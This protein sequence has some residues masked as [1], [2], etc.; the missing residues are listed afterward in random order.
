MGY[1]PL[2]LEPIKA[3]ER[4][5]EGSG[6]INGGDVYVLLKTG[7]AIADDFHVYDGESDRPPDAVCRIRGTGRL[8]QRYSDPERAR[9]AEVDNLEF[10]ANARADIPALIRE[11]EQ[12]RNQLKNRGEQ[13]A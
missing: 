12:L 5:A 3:R 6:W 2:D 1:R 9:Q 4:K 8:N 7:G 13:A 11:V 10:I